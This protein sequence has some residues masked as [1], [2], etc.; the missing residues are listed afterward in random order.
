MNEKELYEYLKKHFIYKDDGTLIRNDKK[1]A[2]GSYD[3]DG[4]LIIK[5]KA[6]QYKSHRLVY[7][8]HNGHMPNGVIDHINRIKTDNRIDN[9]RDVEQ[10]INVYNKDGHI[11]KITGV[12]GV[13][14]DRTYGLKKNYA[15]KKNGKSYR[16]AT[17]E[18]AV[19]ER[20]KLWNLKK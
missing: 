3:K 12:V 13:Y 7:L 2:N 17:V 5:I 4:Y 15:F 14:F 10:Q 16:F 9:L 1:N 11:N 19:I 20:E 18:Q 8:L 6:K